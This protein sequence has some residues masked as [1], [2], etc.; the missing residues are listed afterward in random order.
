MVMFTVHQVTILCITTWDLCRAV[1]HITHFCA[2]RY[3]QD[4][5]AYNPSGYMQDCPANNISLTKNHKVY[6][7][8][9]TNFT[10]NHSIQ[11]FV[12]LQT[13]Q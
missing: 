3:L 13:T 8:E 10:D 12:R 4:G 5:P 11:L 6:M 9:I 1:L 2:I 7:H